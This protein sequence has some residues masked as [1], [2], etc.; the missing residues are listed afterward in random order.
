ML[1]LHH[2]PL[3]HFAKHVLKGAATLSRSAQYREVLKCCL[4]ISTAALLNMCSGVPLLFPGLHNTERFKN[5]VHL[6]CRLCARGCLRS[7]QYREVLKCRL[8][9]ST[10]AL[11][12]M[13]WGVP[14][15]FPSLHN[16]E[17][18]KNVVFSSLLP[19][20]STCARGC[21][22]SPQYREVLKC[23][24]FISTA[25]LLNMCWGVPLRF[26]SLHNREI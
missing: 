21:L 9:I 5:V 20:R 25:A 12:N 13:C 17:R 15:R 7:P 10:A 1:S 26:P 6:H 19:P 3:V 11:L 24:L 4:F 18:F 22:R 16:T 14:L 2:Q 23:R 8:F